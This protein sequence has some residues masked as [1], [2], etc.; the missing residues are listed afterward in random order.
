[1]ISS[2]HDSSLRAYK[3]VPG[4]RKKRRRWGRV[5]QRTTDWEY[6]PSCFLYQMDST[7]WRKAC[8]GSLQNSLLIIISSTAKRT[9]LLIILRIN[10]FISNRDQSFHPWGQAGNES[11]LWK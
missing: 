10:P 8:A 7:M 2:V 5:L 1:M 6:L 3:Q 9:P 4:R 11:F